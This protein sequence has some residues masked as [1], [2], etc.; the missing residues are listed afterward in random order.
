[1][2]PASDKQRAELLEL[3]GRLDKRLNRDRHGNYDWEMGFQV[4]TDLYEEV[5]QAVAALRE[6]A[7][8]RGD[9][10]MR[11][12]LLLARAA[13]DNPASPTSRDRAFTAIA[14]ALAA[15]EPQR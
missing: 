8:E 5:R 3:A 7:K 14:K 11:G 6:A 2:T 4:D 9:A 15:K 12:A 10:D 13:L 1:M